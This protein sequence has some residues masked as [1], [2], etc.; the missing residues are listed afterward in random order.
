MNTGHDIS[1]ANIA[2]IAP[3]TSTFADVMNQLGTDYKTERIPSRQSKRWLFSSKIVLHYQELGIAV[4]FI[5]ADFSLLPKTPVSVVCSGTGSLLQTGDG[6]R[7]GLSLVEAMAIINENYSIHHQ[8][9]G[10]IEIVPLDGESST[11]MG[12]YHNNDQIEFIGLYL[13]E[14]I[15]KS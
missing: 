3:D 8:T 12:I 11:F 14:P 10:C 5:T 15:P 2:G 6:L 9:S 13:R 4:V 1:F 7:V